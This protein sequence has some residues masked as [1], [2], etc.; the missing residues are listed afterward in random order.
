MKR[1]VPYALITAGI[2]I[3]Y[4]L[5]MKLLGLET[6]L[7]LRALNIVIMIGAIYILYRNTFIRDN[8]TRVGYLQGLMMG[9]WFTV[10]SVA[11]FSIFL[12]IYIHFFDPGFIEI[13]DGAGLW[14][15]SGS[16]I[17]LSIMGI[18]IEGLAGGFILSFIL[19]QYFK[20]K[21]KPKAQA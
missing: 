13:I 16:S 7:Y 6:N 17:G 14:A 2:L 8:D 19:M 21:I 15:N 10:L 5:L 20:S 4:F 1:T 11:I 9:I 18:L 12:G 3:A